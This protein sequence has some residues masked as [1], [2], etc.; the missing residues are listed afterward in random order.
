MQRYDNCSKLATLTSIRNGTISVK[1]DKE[2]AI[3]SWMAKQTALILA[4]LL[5][6][7][8]TATVTNPFLILTDIGL[9]IL[10]L[11]VLEETFAPRTLLVAYSAI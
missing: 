2:E 8:V 11:E 10:N 5:S 6:E 3:S 9:K 1:A 4:F 7:T